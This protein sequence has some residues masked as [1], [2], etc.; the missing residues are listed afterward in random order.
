MELSAA[1]LWWLA[2]GVAVAI[3]LVT[4]TFYLLM[5][6]IGLAAAA[7]AAHLGLSSTGQVIAAALV[8]G[9]ATALW[10]WKRASQPRSAAVRENRDANL[11]IGER[12]YVTEWSADRTARVQYRGSGWTARLQVGADAAPGEHIVSAVEGNWLELRPSASSTHPI[13]SR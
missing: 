10:H 4:G 13:S 2:A 7:M 3:E 11:D 1:T 5:M 9:G 12:V 6:A 8:G